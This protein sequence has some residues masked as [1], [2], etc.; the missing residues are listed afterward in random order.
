MNYDVIVIGA[1]PGGYVCAIRAAQM[2]LKVA[3][4]DSRGKPGGTCLNVGCIPSKAL[5]HASENFFSLTNGHTESMGI[6]VQ[7]PTIDIEKMQNYK[8]KIIED[9]VNGIIYLFKKNKIDYT[10]A[11]VEFVDNQTVKTTT[12]TGETQILQAKNIVIASGSNSATLPNIIPDE[13]QILTSTGALKLPFIPKKAIVIGAGAIGLEIGSVWNRLGAQVTVIEYLDG[14]SPAVDHDIASCFVK[15][16]TKQGFKFLFGKSVID[17]QKKQ[18]KQKTLQATIQDK[19]NPEERVDHQA[20]VI[21]VAVGRIPCTEGLNLSA[22]GIEIDTKGCISVNKHWQ[23]SADGVYAIG[24][25]INGPMLAHKAEDEGFAVAEILAGHHGRHIDYSIIPS[26]IYTT[27]EVAS[28]GKTENALKKDK[29]A[30]K[31]GIFSL[32][33]NGRAKVMHATDGMVKILSSTETDRILGVHIVAP[34][35]SEI[36]HECCIAMEFGASS[37][38]IARTCHAHPTLSEA[39][40]EASLITAFGASIHA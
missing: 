17:V 35:A 38:D 3:C 24:D 30:Y 19:N 11:M 34:Y 12:S 10:I 25:V 16:L 14:M 5:L 18:K 15:T 36:I 31:V 9:N 37:E 20:D 2:G 29:I 27:P 1:G 21:L 40:R 8:Q 7:N 23:T 4:I 28:V 33:G 32:V 13:E 26:V 6:S 22:A 39:V